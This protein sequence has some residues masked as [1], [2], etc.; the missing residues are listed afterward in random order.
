MHLLNVNVPVDVLAGDLLIRRD[1]S[2]NGRVVALV[3]RRTLHFVLDTPELLL[4]VLVR[5]DH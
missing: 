3:T 5:D 4:S 2:E 1:G